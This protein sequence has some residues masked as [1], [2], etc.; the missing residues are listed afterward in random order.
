MN[1]YDELYKYPQ[2]AVERNTKLI[3]DIAS[4]IGEIRGLFPFRN[5]GE[6][7]PAWDLNDFK[8]NYLHILKRRERIKECVRTIREKHE[9]LNKNL[10]ERR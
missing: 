9:E 6:L 1:A 7:M 8:T 3:M 10:R 2:E 5:L 4:T